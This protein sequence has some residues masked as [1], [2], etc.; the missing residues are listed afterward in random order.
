MPAPPDHV[1]RLRQRFEQSAFGQRA[2]AFFRRYERLAPALFFFGGV[3]WDASTLNRIDAWFDNAFLLTYLLALGALILVAALVERERI[4]WPWVAKYRAWYPAAIQFFMGALF[5]AYTVFYFQSASLTSTS[6]FMLLLVGLLVANE[7]I[8]RRLLN[9]YLLFA[10]YYFVA[11]SF[12]VFFVPVVAKVMNFWTFLVGGVLS[13]GLVVGMLAFLR[14]HG[15]FERRQFACATGI[16]VALFG[17]LNV[18][19]VYDLMPP[20]PLALR[21]SGIFHHVQSSVGEDGQKVYTLRY[22]QPAWHQFWK[23]SDDTFHYAE[24]DRVYCFAA[25]FAPAQLKK[26]IY[27]E[28]RYYDEAR[29]QWTTTDRISYQITGYEGR[30]RG[31][32][33]YTLKRHVRPGRWRVDIRTDDGHTLGRVAFTVV[34]AGTTPRTFVERVYE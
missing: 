21:Y 6:L 11:F 27:H 34:P 17:L 3:A 28:W 15:I 1:D 26:G 22:E 25:V 19:Y 4:G 30:D 13:L 8:H 2:L 24:G 12:F 7:F 16:V 20:V 29:R 33:G 32:R 18:F 9:L 5:S 14:H 31:Y 10:L 23:R